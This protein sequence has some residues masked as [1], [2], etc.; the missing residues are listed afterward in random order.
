MEIRDEIDRFVRTNWPT[1]RSIFREHQDVPDAAEHERINALLLRVGNRRPT[2][3]ERELFRRIVGDPQRSFGDLRV[4]DY[5]CQLSLVEST[6]ADTP[7]SGVSQ[8][9]V[10][11][12]SW[13]AVLEFCRAALWRSNSGGSVLARNTVRT[14]T[15]KRRSGRRY[16]R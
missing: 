14:G 16:L 5:R 6:A 3:Q 11:S 13:E 15:S 4:E 7:S 2:N 9:E 8:H 10:V 1:L 12:H